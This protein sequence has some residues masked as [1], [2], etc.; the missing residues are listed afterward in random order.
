MVRVIWSE[1]SSVISVLAPDCDMC[2]CRAWKLAKSDLLNCIASLEL[3]PLIVLSHLHADGYAGFN[4]LYEA[5]PKTGEPA[6]LIEVACW[7]HARRKI[8]DVH[9]TTHSPAAA[10]ALEIIARLF[11]IEADIRSNPPEQR[12]A[13][14]RE[15]AIPVLNELRA[16]LGATLAK[17][18]G[19]SDFAGAIRY[20]TS[21]WSALTRYVDNG[22]LEMSNNAAERA[23]RPLALGRK[24]Y[25]FA[26]SDAGGR[27]AAILY[28]LI[29]TARLNDID[30]EA[31]LADVVARIADH[32]INRLDE[33]LPWKWRAVQTQAVAA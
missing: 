31:W 17:I 15:R 5:D 27:R 1:A 12:I 21:R 33:L 19:K 26:G 9:L 28:T 14:R 8:Y 32:P 30:P 6:P 11:A 23:I 13:A 20:T 4:G 2:G 10:Q 7:A 29:E 25:L 16:F 24:N 22:R 3:N 18:S